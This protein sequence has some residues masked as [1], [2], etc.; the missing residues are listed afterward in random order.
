MNV[1]ANATA[2]LNAVQGGQVN[3]S[4][5]FDNAT[6]P[7]MKSAGFTVYPLELNY[8]GLLLLDRDGKTNKALGDVRVRQ[9]INYAFDRPALLKAVASGYGTVTNQI[10]PTSSPAYDKALDSTYPYDPAKAK[11][12]L[13]EAGYPNGFTLD[14]P[15]MS[16]FSSVNALVAQQLGAVGITVKN[17]DTPIP[18]IIDTILSR[19]YSASFFQLQEDPTDWQLVQFQVA[20]G[21]TWNPFHAT[22][23]TIEGYVSTIQTGSAAESAA[24]AKSLNAYLVKNAWFAPWYRPQ[25]SFV[26]DAKTKVTV[27]P[28][29]SVPYLYNIEPK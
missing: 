23:S 26:A 28:G 7:Q 24:A 13:A 6:L 5:T 27:Q 10:F 29:N 19:K 2:L 9:A 12:L 17:H 11:Q 15:T 16:I 14:L 22:D 4:N 20:E 21:A 25:A 18:Q 1:Y 3:A 8:A